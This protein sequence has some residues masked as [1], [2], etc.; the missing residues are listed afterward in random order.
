MPLVKAVQELNNKLEELEK[1]NQSLKKHQQVERS[2]IP[3][4][5]GKQQQ[6][7]EDLKM[8]NEKLKI[9][10]S[11]TD[12]EMMLLKAQVAELSKAVKALRDK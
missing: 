3:A 4:V 11:K 10:N 6:M 8:Q 12:E 9:E 7:I 5:V 1:E 2:E